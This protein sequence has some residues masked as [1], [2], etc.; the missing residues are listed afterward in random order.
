MEHFPTFS[1]HFSNIVCSSNLV[2]LQSVDGESATL[3][4]CE[5]FE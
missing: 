3:V 2:A 5:F 4:K 1:K